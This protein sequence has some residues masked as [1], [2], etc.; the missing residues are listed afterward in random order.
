MTWV[1]LPSGRRHCENWARGWYYPFKMSEQDPVVTALM[2]VVLKHERYIGLI[3]TLAQV[4]ADHCRLLEAALMVRCDARD[5][6][7]SAATVKHVLYGI[8]ACDHCAAQVIVNASALNGEDQ[9]SDLPNAEQIRRLQDH[10]W[11]MTR[12]E[13]I[14]STLQ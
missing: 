4:A 5:V 7:T 8:N 11:A 10:L 2:K 13:E 3:T 12:D 6:C 1:Q 14:P 9:W